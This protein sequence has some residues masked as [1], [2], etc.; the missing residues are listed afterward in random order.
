MYPMEGFLCCVRWDHNNRKTHTQGGTS[1]TTVHHEVIKKAKPEGFNP[2]IRP[3]LVYR[4]HVKCE[5]LCWKEPPSTTWQYLQI[6]S[7][8]SGTIHV[9]S[10]QK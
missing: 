10:T 8:K 6:I 5:Y 2:Q 7:R 1:G 3:M 4:K 9:L